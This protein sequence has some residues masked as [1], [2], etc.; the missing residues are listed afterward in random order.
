[1][2]FHYLL[3]NGLRKDYIFVANVCDST[4]ENFAYEHGGVD[5]EGE[6]ATGVNY[7]VHCDVGHTLTP[8][9]EEG[10]L[11]CNIDGTWPEKPTNPCNG[12]ISFYLCS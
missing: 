5:T 11:L 8:G 2:C 9:E 7:L 6:P 4:E 12:N 10:V 3:F 1:M